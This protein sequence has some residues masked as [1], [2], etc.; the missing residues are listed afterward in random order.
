MWFEQFSD[1][2][3]AHEK[4]S[5]FKGWTRKKKEALISGEFDQLPKLS[6]AYHK[7]TD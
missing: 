2:G 4:E 5:Q 3:F 7:K 6:K 1:K